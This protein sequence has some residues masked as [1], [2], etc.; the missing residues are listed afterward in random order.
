MG[1]KQEFGNASLEQKE[2]VL[3]P[4]LY[5]SI[6]SHLSPLPLALEELWFQ[7]QNIPKQVPVA[8]S[9]PDI[10]HRGSQQGVFASTL[11]VRAECPFPHL[12]TSEN[13]MLERV[14]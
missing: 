8:P 3:W 1:V 4:W 5:F 14:L 13:S 10:A 2:H 7:Y 9:L 12:A 11:S 6:L